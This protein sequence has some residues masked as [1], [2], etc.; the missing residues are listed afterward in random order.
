[1]MEELKLIFSALMPFLLGIAIGYNISLLVDINNKL[2]SIIKSYET[3]TSNSS[4][5][6]PNN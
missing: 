2:N 5:Y 6:S 3:K 1:M 4:T